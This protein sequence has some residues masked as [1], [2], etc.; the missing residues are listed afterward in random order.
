MFQFLKKP[1][2][3]NDDLKHNAKVIFFI[4]IGILT[5]LYL[6]KPFDINS[7]K[8]VEQFYLIGGLFIVIFLALSINLLVIPSIFPKLFTFSPWTIRKEI[9]WNLWILLTITTGNFLCYH[10]L[11]I[12]QFDFQVILQ[13]ILVAVVPISILISIN[14]DRLIRSNLKTAIELNKKLQEKKLNTE[15]MI[16]FQSDYQKDSLS[17]PASSIILIKSAGNYIEVHWSEKDSSQNKMIRSS[18]KKSSEILKDFSFIF[19]CHRSF[20][21]NINYLEKIEGSYQGYKLFL[22]LID[23]PIPVSQKYVDNFK[24]MI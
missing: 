12:L 2:P 1:Y 10:F 15:K 8:S 19:Q 5:F 7:L 17:I 9:I 18:L 6:F 23:F 14:Q 13:I 24:E 21:I 16:F 4:S 22:K 11:D 20:I 3:F